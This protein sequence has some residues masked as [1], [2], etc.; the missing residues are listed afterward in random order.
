MMQWLAA[1]AGSYLIGSIPTAFLVVKR[2]KGVDVRTVGSG[3]VGATN[4][5]RAAGFRAGLFVFSIDVAKGLAAVL[6]VAPALQPQ[7]A[8]LFRLACGFAAVVGHIFPLFLKFHGGKG[9]A[10]TI[11]VL[12]SVYPGV[13]LICGGVWLAGF[14]AGRY[15][16]VASIAAMACLPPLLFAMQRPP[17]EIR[18]GAALALLVILKHR[19]NIQRLLAGT[20]HRVGRPRP[21]AQGS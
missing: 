11:G 16:S 18:L 4:V 19:S 12:A 5:T 20:E 9:V 17:A 13:A 10:T 14:L 3:N 21:R 6:L 1:L 7:P 8:P 15:V 2:L